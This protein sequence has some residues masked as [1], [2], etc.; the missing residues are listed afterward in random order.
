MVDLDFVPTDDLI[1]GLLSRYDE[2]V[3]VGDSRER[4]G[5]VDLRWSGSAA[6]ARGWSGLAYDYF[7]DRMRFS[8][9]TEPNR[10]GSDD[11]E[12]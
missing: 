2:A 3:F 5:T 6:A 9:M 4:G 1:E 8:L 7:A 11:E 10:L 12:E